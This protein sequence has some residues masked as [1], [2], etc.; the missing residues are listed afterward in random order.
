MPRVTP[1]NFGVR[2]GEFGMTVHDFGGGLTDDDKIQD[3][4]L[5]R[6]FVGEEIGF[7]QT[8]HESARIGG[9]LTDVFEV[10]G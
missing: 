6:A 8:F 10:I 4:S 3:D 9:G 2:L 5:L 1:R 7:H